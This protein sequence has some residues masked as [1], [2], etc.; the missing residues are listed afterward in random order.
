MRIND[1]I[2]TQGFENG[3][4]IHEKRWRRID[5]DEAKKIL[6]NW[7]NAEYKL[8]MGTNPYAPGVIC[9]IPHKKGDYSLFNRFWLDNVTT[10]TEK[11]ILGFADEHFIF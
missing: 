8:K 9:V 3:K 11:E 10:K 7:Q 5:I 4:A 2:P 1:E 6:K